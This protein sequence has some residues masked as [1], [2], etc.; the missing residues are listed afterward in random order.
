MSERAEATTDETPGP[1]PGTV[2]DVY[3][4]IRHPGEGA[5]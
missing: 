1:A 5:L 4:D 2:V 3:D